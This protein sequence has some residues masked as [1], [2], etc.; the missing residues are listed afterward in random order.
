MEKRWRQVNAMK[1]RLGIEMRARGARPAPLDLRSEQV[2]EW[3]PDRGRHDIEKVDLFVE[4]LG[5][6]KRQT[7]CKPGSVPRLGG[8]MAIHLGRPSPDASR[9]LP[10]RRRGNPP[11][12]PAACRPYSVLLP[13]GFTVPPPSPG[14]RCALTA[15]FHPCPA[16]APRGFGVAVCFLR[17]FPWGRP[18]RAL[19]GTA[20]PW[21]PDFPPPIRGPKA[22]IRPSGSVDVRRATLDGQD[23]CW[24]V[25]TT[26]PRLSWPNTEQT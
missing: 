19:P 9:D 14:A 10:G 3:M 8:A 6:E 7:A 1:C 21:S 11:G 17:H 16:F 18:R 20:F 15:P 12:R 23:Q 26:R 2:D 22:A 25:R 24:I 4:R 5:R 13:V